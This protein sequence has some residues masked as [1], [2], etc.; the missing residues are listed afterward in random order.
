V[1]LGVTLIGESLNDLADPRLRARRKPAE[2]T[3]H[4]VAAEQPAAREEL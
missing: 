2:T 3:G 1:V 4:A